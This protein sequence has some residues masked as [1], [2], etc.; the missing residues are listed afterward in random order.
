MWTIRAEPGAG[1]LSEGPGQ[2]AHKDNL[3]GIQSLHG[4][5][6]NVFNPIPYGGGGL[7]KPPYVFFLSVG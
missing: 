5:L 4:E 3:Q 7:P 6:L 1:T 2:S